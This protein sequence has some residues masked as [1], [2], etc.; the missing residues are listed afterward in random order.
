MYCLLN[1]KFRGQLFQVCLVNR[2]MPEHLVGASSIPL[3]VPPRLQDDY[4]TS[5]YNMLTL[6][7][8]GVLILFCEVLPRNSVKNSYFYSY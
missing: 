7:E 5:R 3:A 8:G 6:V 4:N 2:V 1:K